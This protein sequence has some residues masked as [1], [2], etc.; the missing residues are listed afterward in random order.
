MLVGSR[1]QVACPDDSELAAFVE[2][3]LNGANRDAVER[4]LDACPGCRETI[5]HLAATAEGQPHRI[6]RY[7]LDRVIGSGGMGVVWQAWD[8]ALERGLAIKLLRPEATSKLGSARLVREARALARLQH[9]NVIAIHDVGE[10]AGD[11]FIATELVDGESM[12]RWQRGRA[13]GELIAAYAQAARGLAAA[14]RLGLVH[15][16]VKPSNILV[17]RDGRVRV[18]DFGLAT[19]APDAAPTEPGGGRPGTPDPSLTYDGAVVGTP[20]YMAPEQ[21]DGT[22]VDARADQFSL[23]LALAEALVGERPASDATAAELA[24]RG[25]AAPWQAIARGL[26]TRPADRYPDLGPLIA[27]LAAWRD[28]TERFA[29]GD[30]VREP[31]AAGNP[32]ASVRAHPWRRR[33]V[34]R[35]RWAVVIGAAFA[36]AL[37]AYHRS[38]KARLPPPP[39]GAAFANKARPDASAQASSALAAARCPEGMVPVS[40]GTFQM[41]SPNG[42]GDEDEH[43]QHQVTLSKYCID[44]MEVTVEAYALCVAAK[45]CSAAPITVRWGGYS[46]EQVKL[47]SP[48]CN[49]I[50]DDRQNHPINCV[51]WDQAKA[52]CAWAGKRL[53]T[54]AEWEYAARGSDGRKYPWGNGE[55]SATRL[56]ACG[57]E[58]VAMAKRDLKLDWAKMYEASDGSETTA[59]VGRFPDGASPF[60]ALDMAGNV[61]EWTA[62]WYS[63]Y[64]GAAVT[65]PHGANTGEARVI[66]G[67]GWYA[68]DA[69]LVRAADRTRIRA[70]YRHTH[71][72]FRCARGG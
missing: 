45:S 32:G 19:R 6:G 11:L 29:S 12:D 59:P 66:R 9:P 23:C 61:W 3:T 43:P 40:A 28:P 16:D 14:H 20:A 62:D 22:P 50:R 49:V 57:S 39:I 18:G 46:E 1:Y 55:P 38:G 53:P 71:V 56:N 48:F 17:G 2:R 52:Y 8:P 31:L 63:A 30:A 58:C 26:A 24:A 68:N 7:R 70:S 13:P 15:R 60:G 10:L 27:A 64:A 72:G 5:A 69:A 36:V 4:H 34:P 25:I 33:P 35:S 67:G 47:Y 41:G 54:E 21:R 65:N 51:D 44:K 37:L 42:V